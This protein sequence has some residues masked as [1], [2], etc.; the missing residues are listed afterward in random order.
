MLEAMKSGYGRGDK[1]EEPE[2]ATAAEM[3]GEMYDA[4]KKGDREAYIEACLAFFQCCMDEEE[5]GGVALVIG[6]K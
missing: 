2:D 6:R 5:G 3:A 1:D 4:S